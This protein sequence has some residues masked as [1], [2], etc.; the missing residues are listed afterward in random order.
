MNYIIFD[1]E[2]NQSPSA[3]ERDNDKPPFEILEIGAVKLNENRDMIGEFSELIRPQIYR[4]IHYITSRLV[5]LHMEELE[6]GRPFTE[7]VRKFFDWCGDD[8][9]FCTWGALD[10]TELQRNMAYYK[11]PPMSDRPIKFIDVQKLFSLAYEDGKSRRTLEYAIDVL[12]IKK[13][14]PFHRAFSDA[15]YTAKV[16]D[17]IEDPEVLEKYSFDLYHIPQTKEQEI[18]INFSNYDK[19]ISR[20]FNNKTA[21][22]ADKEVSSCRC[23]KC[24]RNLRKKEKWF[25]LNNK[26]YIA[27]G[28]C[29]RHGYVKSKIRVRKAENGVYAVKTDKYITKD[30]YKNILTKRDE[31]IALRRMKKEEL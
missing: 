6:S 2:W 26:H 19:H 28:Y 22:M 17:K 10:L 9:V 11:L 29:F 4:Q 27:I 24:R 31:T 16:F 25:T 13:D 3:V 23:Y 15:Y 14:I 21:L 5:H 18:R 20:V 12:R 30:D 8:C 1:L 7:V